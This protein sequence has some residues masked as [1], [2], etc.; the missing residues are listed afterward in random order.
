M[1]KKTNT[2]KTQTT[3]NK[4]RHHYAWAVFFA[5]LFTVCLFLNMSLNW[6]I[7]HFGSINM[8]NI[9]FTLS[10]PL[11]GGGTEFITDFIGTVAVPVLFILAGLLAVILIVAGVRRICKKNKIVYKIRFTVCERR[12]KEISLPSDRREKRKKTHP[13]VVRTLLCSGAV[14]W[15]GVLVMQADKNFNLF[16]YLNAQLHPSVFIEQQYVDPNSVEIKFPEKKRNLIYI[17]MESAETSTQDVANGGLF[18]QNYTPEM[19][20]IANDNVSFSHTDKLD[21]ALAA[22]GGTWTT[23]GMVCELAGLPLKLPPNEN[24][25]MGGFDKFLPG[26]TNLGDILEANGYNNYWM[27]GSTASFGGCDKY[28]IQHGNHEIFDFQT[29][30]NEGKV[31]ADYNIGW[32]GLEDMKVYEYAKEKLTELD[33]KDEPFN[34]CMMTIDTHHI[35]GYVCPL[36]RNEFEDQYANVWA[37]ASR[38]VNDFINWCKEQPFYEDTTI[39]VAGD[40]WSM[41]PYFYQSFPQI[42]ANGYPTRKVYNAF[43]NSAVE[44]VQQ[45]NRQFT[46]MDLFPSTLAAMGVEIE[47]NRLALGTNL[48][49]DQKTLT[50]EFGWSVLF[51]EMDKVSHFY[52]D[53]LFSADDAA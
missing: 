12:T 34:F 32:W 3:A 16:Q 17:F 40:H 23:G 48:F 46:T 19:T 50:E 39:V 31:P 24:N 6:A 10:M 13:A 35:G 8:D 44:P 37:C 38:Q 28:M 41:D 18:N 52:S 29:A 2:N 45:K 15:I 25:K 43:V 47:G 36:C 20:K 1:K 30:I 53:K 7:A 26:V 5:V 49:S 11:D 9:L 4:K 27:I 51:T 42:D 33:A 22:P 21:G 14:V